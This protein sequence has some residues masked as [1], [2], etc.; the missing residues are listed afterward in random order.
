[1]WVLYGV[2]M[3]KQK[4]QERRKAPHA[5]R[6]ASEVRDDGALVELIYD[7]VDRKTS[8]VVSRDGQWQFASSL[9]SGGRR[10]VPFSPQ[11]NL[12]NRCTRAPEHAGGIR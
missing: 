7:P 1:M 10:I 8:F 3:D 4:S 9:E 2:G 5:D 11:N 12:T 6:I